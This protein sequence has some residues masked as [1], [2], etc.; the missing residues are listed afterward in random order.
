M[1]C[2]PTDQAAAAVLAKS[3]WQAQDYDDG[4]NCDRLNPEGDS[5]VQIDPAIM[6][7]GAADQQS[8]PQKC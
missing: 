5:R 2:L 3:D 1:I 6:I 8:M 7:S 4:T